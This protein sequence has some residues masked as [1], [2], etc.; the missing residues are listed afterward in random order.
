MLSGGLSDGGEHTYLFLYADV[1]HFFSTQDMYIFFAGAAFT[2]F[3]FY[4]IWKYLG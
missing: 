1:D 2:F 3:C 4:M